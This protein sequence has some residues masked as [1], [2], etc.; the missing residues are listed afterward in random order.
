MSRAAPSSQPSMQAPILGQGYAVARPGGQCSVTAVAIGPGEKFMALLKETEAGL[1]RVDVSM[2]AWPQVDHRAALAY[3]QTVMPKAGEAKR[4]P[5]VDDEILMQLFERLQDTE[6]ELKQHFRFVLGL[7]LMRK[8][9]LAYE[10]SE[11]TSAGEIWTIKARGRDERLRLLN[12]QLTEEQTKAVAEQL[13]Q[14]M[15]EEL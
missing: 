8:R 5:L 6:E 9:L 3:W 11:K 15:N 2:A 10:T 4:K 14:I 1:E 12:P 7:I 13:G